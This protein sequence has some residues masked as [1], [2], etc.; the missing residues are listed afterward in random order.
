[1]QGLMYRYINLI[2]AMN[3]RVGRIMMYG[4]FVMMGILLWSSISKTFF[5]P[6]L[7][8]LEVAQFAMVAYY[9][10]GGPYSIQM[11]S[12]VRMDL[13]YGEWSD[14][15]KAQVDAMTVL[16]LI[17]YLGFL[18]WG[19]WESLM[20]SFS[21]GGER[22][23]SV[24]RPY[25]WPIKSIMVIGIFLMLLQA[26]SEFFKDILRIKGHDVGAKL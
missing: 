23:S 18:L 8:T 4:I 7:W 22:S 19:G 9:M 14:H 11:G 10:L 24:W 13:L 21:Y 5:V 25:L 17:V 2:D 1:M 16:F 20:Y 3:Y 15:R 12:N 6:S 26:V